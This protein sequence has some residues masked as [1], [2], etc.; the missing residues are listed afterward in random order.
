MKKIT[1][2]I[3]IEKMIQLIDNTIEKKKNNRNKKFYGSTIEK[4]N[5]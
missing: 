5:V 4:K 2:K 3:I 1:H